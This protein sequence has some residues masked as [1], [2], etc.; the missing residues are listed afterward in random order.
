MSTFKITLLKAIEILQFNLKE[1][2]LKMPTDCHTAVE[3]ALDSMAGLSAERNIH[4]YS[5]IGQLPH[6][7]R[8]DVN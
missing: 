7:E 1:A 4:G 2:G 8:V 3:L 5:R 6:E